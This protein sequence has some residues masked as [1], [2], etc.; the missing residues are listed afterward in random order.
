MRQVIEGSGAFVRFPAI[1]TYGLSVGLALASMT[2]AQSTAQT[3]DVPSAAAQS[4]AGQPT[5]TQPAADRPAPVIHVEKTEHDFG[6]VWVGSDVQ[7]TFEIHN[8]GN[9][10]LE[11][12]SVR[13]DCGCTTVGDYPKVIQ[14]GQSGQF[15]F[16]LKT[17]GLNGR[18]AP[19][20]IN[21]ASNDPVT[22]NLTLQLVGTFR[23]RIDIQ[24]AAASFGTIITNEPITQVVRIRNNTDT[25]LKL[26]LQPLASE[27]FKVGL[28]EKEP[29]KVFELSF[30]TVTPYKPGFLGVVAN[31]QTNIEE[32]KILRVQ[33]SGRVPHRLDLY[34]SA[35][36]FTP[37]PRSMP[38]Q[39]QGS[40]QFWLNNYGAS[41]VNVKQASVDDAT[42][43]TTVDARSPGKAFRIQVD[44]PAGAVI[45]AEGRVLTVETDDSELP[46]LQ[47]RIYP[48]PGQNPA[49][50]N[51]A[52]QTQPATPRI[53]PAE[54]LV[55]K[56]A[57]AFS[58]DTFD[59]RP[60]GSAD[61]VGK[62]TVL[63]FVSP[64][65]GFCKKQI[66]EL[67]KIRAAYQDKG[68]RFVNV[69]TTNPSG[70]REYSAAEITQ[71]MTSLGSH[72]E[73]AADTG[74]GVGRM[75]Q[76]DGFPTCVVVGKDARI[77]AVNIGFNKVEFVRGQLDA[78]LAG[79]PVPAAS[80]PQP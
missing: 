69:V 26:E 78:L 62:V 79:K 73:V 27:Q 33:A 61:L 71:L 72:L 6:D 16:G 44:V 12:R 14:P 36:R 76:V 10:P 34:P 40:L 21:I 30:T 53:R 59:G 58:L 17:T 42:F 9:A 60:I 32:E 20:K 4:T 31:L 47:A 15:L 54:L 28:T 57:P 35:T 2:F 50:A 68:I 64:A 45:P 38:G 5:A 29:G 1:F 46:T 39:N 51:L 19:K 43:K 80:R 13:V 7:Q 65:C 74:F 56:P 67:E 55:G 70:R 41:L 37:S 23:K 75:F 3:G 8:R 77:A 22:P 24:P 48:P 25:R 52:A 18:I 63:N 49:P 66:P 11:I